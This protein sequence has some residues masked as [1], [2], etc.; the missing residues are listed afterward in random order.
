M[1]MQEILLI[2]DL[3]VV[4]QLNGVAIQSEL[5]SLSVFEQKQR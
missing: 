2:R 4:V 5:P 3:I 1:K